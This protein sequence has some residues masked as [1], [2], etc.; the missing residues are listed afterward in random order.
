MFRETELQFDRKTVLKNDEAEKPK[1][2]LKTNISKSHERINISKTNDR[3]S[4][5]TSGS[6]LGLLIMRPRHDPTKQQ[7]HNKHTWKLKLQTILRNH[8]IQGTILKLQEL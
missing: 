3:L 5:N 7:L 8:T 6:Q 4:C 2:I 1:Y